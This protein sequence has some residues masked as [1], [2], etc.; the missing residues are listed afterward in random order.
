[1]TTNDSPGQRRHSV[2]DE[3]SLIL[4]ADA[5]AQAEARNGLRQ[6]DLG[7]RMIE[8]GIGL[9]ARFKLRPSA[10]LSL[11]REALNG[12]SP[13][14]G[15]WRPAAVGIQGSDHQPVDAH[16]VPFRIEEMCDYINENWP[17]KT[18]IHLSAYAMWRLNW[19]HPFS[20][21]NGRTSR[22]VSYLVLSVK[23]GYVLPGTVT[24]PE[25]IVQNRLPYFEALEAA[26]KACKEDIVDVSA[27][28]ALLEQCLAMQLAKVLDA[29]S[30]K[31]RI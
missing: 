15:N 4:D 30:G 24:I 31:A 14:A 16:L 8:E 22:I 21:G 26:D 29:A 12:L 18:A 3:A 28:E 20:D 25:Q 7:L 27:M 5:K 1:M 6:F 19:I 10:V 2:A 11:H 23:T 9:G 17:H 13:Y